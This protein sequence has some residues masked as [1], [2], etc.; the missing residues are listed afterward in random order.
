MLDE[1]T[2]EVVKKSAPSILVKV[3]GMLI[4]LLVSIALGRLLGAEGLGIINLTTKISSILIIL[5]LLGTPQLLIKELA[6][7]VNDKNWQEVKSLIKSGLIVNSIS[8]LLLIALIVILAPWISKYIFDNKDITI[9]LVVATCAVLFQVISRVYA[10]GIIAYK[11]IWQSNLVN[12]GLSIAVVGVL[13]GV[14]Y[15]FGFTIDVIRVAVFYFVGRVVVTTYVVIYWRT[16]FKN[17]AEFHNKSRALIK[18]SFPFLMVSAT[19]IIAA[20]I[21]SVMVGWLS[22]VK[23]VAY[24]TVASRIALLTIFFLQV[25]NAALSPKLAT[26]YKAGKI[27][28]M[29]KMVQ[30][31][32]SGLICVAILPVIVFA[33]FG[34]S[35]LGLWGAEFSSGYW[36]LIV[37][38]LGQLVNI[39]TGSAGLLLV[40]TGFEKI[41]ANISFIAIG[42]NL[43]INFILI[44]QFGALGAAIATAIAL[45]FENI[46]KV[47]YAKKKTG[48]MTLPFNF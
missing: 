14:W 30:R 8:A 45:S 6:I 3:L 7:A 13:L 36:L 29:N 22:S 27:K 17:K 41:Q 10:S 32:T 9:P 5:A 42:I 48:V 23:E 35:I 18:K 2:L 20:N 21:D 15:V 4:A 46:S 26:L 34:E 37:L 31:V 44:G 38:S 11:K 40:M 12:E 33:L 19:A 16:L 28:E 39:G 1:H 25:T 43:L 47:I 24:Y